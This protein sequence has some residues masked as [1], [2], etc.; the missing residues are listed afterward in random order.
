[1]LPQRLNLG[2]PIK[3]IGEGTKWQVCRPTLVEMAWSGWM[4]RIDK[5]KLCTTRHRIF[6]G[7]GANTLDNF[8]VYG[9]Q[10]WLNQHAFFVIWDTSVKFEHELLIIMTARLTIDPKRINFFKDLVFTNVLN[11]DRCPQRSTVYSLNWLSP[12]KAN[13]RGFWQSNCKLA[14]WFNKVCS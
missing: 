3:K 2:Y 8:W 12:V 4:E 5:L 11:T 14:Y 7:P 1:M 6:E 10:V 9:P 13:W